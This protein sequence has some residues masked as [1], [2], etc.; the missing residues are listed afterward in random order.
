[1]P[2]KVC[3]ECGATHSHRKNR[4]LYCLSCYDARYCTTECPGC[5]GRMRRCSILC[6]RCK[7]GEP[8]PIQMTTDQIA[9][10]AGI[11]EGEGSFVS[12]KAAG[13]TVTMTDL[14]VSQRL[15]QVTG[16]GRIHPTTKR[17]EHHKDAWI[18]AVRR[19]THIR[20]IIEQVQ[21]WL[22][23][24]RSLAAVKLLDRIAGARD[25]SET[26]YAARS[27]GQQ[28]GALPLDDAG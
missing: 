16:V 11:L 13:I 10:L 9:W 1:M 20:Q 25:R 2:S 24:R 26:I 3:P 6:A 27:P 5:G 23:E 15:Q 28:P 4:S 19:R 17:Q 18:W 12:G 7:W 8:Q 22:G 14:D 21:P